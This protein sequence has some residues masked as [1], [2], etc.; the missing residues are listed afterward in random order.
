[1]NPTD[2]QDRRAPRAPG[3]RVS[4]HRGS[5]A[6]WRI[7]GSMAAGDAGLGAAGRQAVLA[8][9]SAAAR[10]SGAH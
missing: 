8:L 7:A 1:M 2:R 3:A 6:G 4:A 9:R 5:A 10:R